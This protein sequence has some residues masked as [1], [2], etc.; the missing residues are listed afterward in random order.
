MVDCQ[1]ALQLFRQ[2]FIDRTAV[3]E[4]AF[5]AAQAHMN[6]CQTCQTK[7]TTLVHEIQHAEEVTIPCETCQAR[8][9]DYYEVL[10]ANE[11]LPDDLLSVG[12]HLLDCADCTAELA[13]LT[14]VMATANA[15]ALPPLPIKPSIDL[16]FLPKSIGYWQQAE[17]KVRRLFSDVVISIRQG[18]AQF[19]PMPVPLTPVAVLGG[20][21][22]SNDLQT[23]SQLLELHKTE[24]GINLTLQTLPKADQG[25]TLI[26]FVKDAHTDTAVANLRIRLYD[27]ERR[28]LQGLM[29][30]QDGAVRFQALQAG[31]YLIQIRQGEHYDEMPVLIVNTA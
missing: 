6:Q 8:L 29:T 26:V 14:E 3:D 22:R 18:V 21:M 15:N 25:V 5:Q 31:R 7:T 28:M 19:G 20:A 16:S 11:L 9:A 4:T 23:P 1:Q 12:L 30:E 10:Q 13:M 2:R 17:E 27:S 24:S